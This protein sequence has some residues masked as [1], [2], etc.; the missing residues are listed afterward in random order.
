MDLSDSGIE[1]GSP[2]FLGDSLPTELPGKSMEVTCLTSVVEHYDFLG[3]VV[4]KN[5]SLEWF[6]CDINL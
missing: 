2:A 4:N 6:T 3:K 1:L 5:L